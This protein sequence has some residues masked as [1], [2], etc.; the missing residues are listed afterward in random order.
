MSLLQQNSR[1]KITLG[2]DGNALVLLVIFNVIVYILL[3]FIKLTYIF[4]DST[5]G[6]FEAQVLS[7][8]SVPAQPAVFATRPWTLLLYMF[9]HYD[10]WELVSS[11]LWLWCFGYILQLVSGNKKLIPI[12]IYGGIAGSVFFLLAANLIPSLRQNVNSIFP[13]LGAGSALMALAVAVTTLAPRFRIFPM[14]KIPLWV[15]TMVFVA[16]RI[17]TA[18]YT[19]KAQVVGLLAGGLMG[20]LFAWQLQRGNDLGQWMSDLVNWIDD[21]FNPEKKTKT[22][23]HKKQLFYLAN[24]KPYEKT[25]HITQQRI[26]D[27]LDK[28]NVKGYNSLTE[29]EKAFLKKASREEF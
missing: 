24:Q 21:F 23:P 6:V 5:V 14:L 17:G 28:I 18:G 9:S 2:Q 29:E 15:L 22:I 8:F 1:I 10:V 13:L 16:V 4:N 3:N 19:N 7:L 12:Y 26:D 20:A 11:M 25:P 27:L